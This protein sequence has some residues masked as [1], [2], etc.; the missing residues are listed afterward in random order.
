MRELADGDHADED[1]PHDGHPEDDLLSLGGRVGC[2]RDE[3]GGDATT[4]V[5][6]RARRGRARPPR[7]RLPRRPVSLSGAESL[8]SRSAARASP[9]SARPSRLAVAAHAPRPRRAPRH[10]AGRRGRSD[11]ASSATRQL[12]LGRDPYE[13]VRVEVVAAAAGPCP[14]RPV[15]RAAGGRSGRYTLVDPSLDSERKPP[16]AERRESGSRSCSP[17]ASAPRA[18]A[19]FRARPRARSR[20]SS[21]GEEVCNRFDRPVDLLVAVREREEHGRRTARGAT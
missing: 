5:A 2:E 12:A 3:H 20:P 18:T 10:A 7:T 17:Q 6:G 8:P 1:E 16:L 15:R 9:S 19:G 21:A 13:P 14:R 4:R 11:S